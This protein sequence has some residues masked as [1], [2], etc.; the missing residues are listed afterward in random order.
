MKSAIKRHYSQFTSAATRT[1]FCIERTGL[2]AVIL[3]SEFDLYDRLLRQVRFEHLN[4][5]L[6]HSAYTEFSSTGAIAEQW[7]LLYDTNGRVTDTFGF[8]AD[9]RP[10][11]SESQ[12][13]VC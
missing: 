2:D 5:K 10:I 8:D 9:G 12:A 11:E 6:A 1:V 7:V 3:S 4:G 13:L